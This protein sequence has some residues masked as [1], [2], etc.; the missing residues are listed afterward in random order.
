MEDIAKYMQF[1]CS[2]MQIIIIS[3]MCAETVTSTGVTHWL[4][5][6]GHSIQLDHI[7]MEELTHDGCLLEEL[8][9]VHVIS[10]LV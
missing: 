5:L 1:M 6:C 7:G 8:D 2:V 3:Q 9:S 4:F 10:S